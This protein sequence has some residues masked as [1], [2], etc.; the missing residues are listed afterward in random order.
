MSPVLQ[1]P[2]GGLALVD[3]LR[4]AVAALAIA[5]LPGAA[6]VLAFWPPGSDVSRLDRV[7]WIGTLS[8]LLVGGLAM[9]LARLGALRIEP[10]A[11]GVVVLI[12]AGV[13]ASAIRLRNS[14]W[15]PGRPDVDAGQ[16]LFA[17]AAVAI[18]VIV[19]LIP[20]L[21]IVIPGGTPLGSITW[22][23]WGLATDVVDAAAIPAMSAEWGGSYPYQGDYVLFSA[24]SA[25][26]PL[27]AGRASDFAL[28]EV[29]RLG[30]VVWAVATALAALRR[31]LPAWGALTGVMILL[32]AEFIA[33]KFAGYRPEAFHYALIFTA[34]WSVDRFREQPT[35]WRAVPIVV[36]VAAL[37]IG[38]GVVLVIAGLAA[39]AVVAGRWLVDRRPTLRELIAFAA[40]GV[41]GVVAAIATD[42]IVQGKVLLI[43]NAIDPARIQGATTTDLTWQFYQWALG[44]P[45]LQS[46]NPDDV[47]TLWSSRIVLPWPI[48]DTAARWILAVVALAPIALWRWLPRSERAL[49]AA[50]WLFLAGLTVVV[51]GFLVLYDTYVPQRVG[52]GRLAPFSLI[53]MGFLITVGLTAIVHAFA[54]AGRARSPRA[55]TVAA[56]AGWGAVLAISVV[57][58]FGGVRDGTIPHDGDALSPDG[59]KALTWL[60]DNTPDDAIVLANAY[61]EGA[62]GTI[63][64]RNGL[65]DGR[66]PYNKE[67]DFLAKAVDNLK[68]ARSFFAGET[69]VDA[70]RELG[71][72]YVV[73]SPQRFGLA[74]PYRFCD[75]AAELDRGL[76]CFAT[77]PGQRPGLTEVARFGEI[78][79]YQIG[80]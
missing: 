75:P 22:Y 74:N 60:R 53:G 62:I 11:A 40:V 29:L 17:A 61:T 1:M 49:Y 30:A 72:D 55:S 64:R 23:Y 44:G 4:I 47:T 3:L 41:A 26:L 79:I 5:V 18:P 24:Y 38:H 68:V 51:A 31:F 52:F 15:R 6:W 8:Y 39:A 58:A 27:L 32:G 48:L 42:A 33:S 46:G 66:A 7:A 16:L 14:G 59:Y 76:P 28:M 54:A 25:V 65:T 43:A 70:I 80:S 67:F 13:V 78:G 69:G 45:F 71:V 10:V 57:I 2:D 50:G 36:T 9:G 34:I 73:V 56:V 21:R 37:W 35:R 12:V 77:D 63:A 20:Q 19:L